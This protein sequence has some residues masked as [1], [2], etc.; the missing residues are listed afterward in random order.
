MPW[1]LPLSNIQDNKS[2][3]LFCPVLSFEPWIQSSSRMEAMETEDLYA[4]RSLL[5]YHNNTNP[6]NPVPSIT[7]HDESGL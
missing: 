2:G 4:R 6:K 7:L 1:G 5:K 3:G